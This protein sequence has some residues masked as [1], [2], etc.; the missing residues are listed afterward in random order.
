MYYTDDRSA[1]GGDYN[2]FDVRAVLDCALEYANG[3]FDGRLDEFCDAY[4]QIM[5]TIAKRKVRTFRF[6]SIEM[7]RR[8]GVFDGIYTAINHIVKG[9]FLNSFSEQRAQAAFVIV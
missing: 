7:K 9:V 1:G 4:Y 6:H 3:A 8:C 5:T 2:A